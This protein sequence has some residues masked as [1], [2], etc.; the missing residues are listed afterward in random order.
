[1]SQKNKIFKNILPPLKLLSEKDKA[2]LML[3]LKKL[4]FAIE[5]LIAA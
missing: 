4:D 2:E 1:M 5:D 3:N